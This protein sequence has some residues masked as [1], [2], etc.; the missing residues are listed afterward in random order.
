MS[1]GTENWRGRTAPDSLGRVVLVIGFLIH[2]ALFSSLITGWAD[3]FFLE[4]ETAYGQAADYFG[5]H[6][7]GQ[8]LRDGNSIYDSHHFQGEADLVVPYFYFYR[9]LPPTAY[10]SAAYGAA[11]SPWTGYWVW[12]VINE[13]VLLLFLA[14]VARY[15]GLPSS[16][17]NL[18]IGVLLGFTPFYLEQW[19]GQYS[20][21]MT[22]FLWL[23]FRDVLLRPEA[24]AVGADKVRSV[25]RWFTNGGFWGWTG[26]LVLKSFSALYALP[27]IRR[28][29]WKPVLLSFGLVAVVCGLHFALHPAELKEFLRLNLRPTPPQISPVRYGPIAVV[30]LL[31]IKA[32][33]ENAHQPVDL[34]LKSSPLFHIPIYIWV[35]GVGLLTAWVTWTHAR[36]VPL[37]R[38][39]ALWSVAFF[40]VFKDVWENHHF[41]LIPAILAGILTSRSIWPWLILVWLALPSLN[42]V[43]P[44]FFAQVP[45]DT[46]PPYWWLLHHVFYA[47]PVLIFYG[48][49][50]WWCRQD[51]P[52]Y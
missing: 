30:H 15:P 17:R 43:D 20:V 26:S 39:F 42:F 41:M 23:A 21:V 7:A 48:W 5:I 22:L 33:G 52:E 25:G 24:Y 29:H 2:V 34:I 9:Y 6:Q 45:M 46:W 32:L 4:A 1:L 27:M 13:I 50:V 16:T 28:G 12:V 51:E 44:Q 18:L 3:R 31:V 19:M 11:F 49:C 8:N 40:L 47:I 37:E 10:L 38:F 35:L 36:R 14:S